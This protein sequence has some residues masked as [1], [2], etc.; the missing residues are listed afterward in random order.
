MGLGVGLLMK[1][2]FSILRSDNL[3]SFSILRSDNL[4]SFRLKF[5]EKKLDIVEFHLKVNADQSVEEILSY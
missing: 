4:I 2:S 3:I 5:N 1:I